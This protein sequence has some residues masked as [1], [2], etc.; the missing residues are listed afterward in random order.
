MNE[1]IGRFGWSCDHVGFEHRSP[2]HSCAC[3]LADSST[4]LLP[5]PASTSRP[6]TPYRCVYNIINSLIP[7]NSRSRTASTQLP[8]ILFQRLTLS[9]RLWTWLSAQRSSATQRFF[10]SYITQHSMQIKMISVP[11]LCKRVLSD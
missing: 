2:S 4:C 1:S 6:V 11:H 8:P 3:S 9:A 5:L 7:Y 10:P